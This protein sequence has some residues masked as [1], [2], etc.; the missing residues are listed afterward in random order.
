MSARKQ[1]PLAEAALA[2]L[3]SDI[4]ERFGLSFPKERW[5]DLERGLRAAAGDLRCDPM[6]L[7]ARLHSSKAR[8]EEVR[9]LA[10]RLT[11]G[12]TYFLRESRGLQFLSQHVVPSAS[13]R[14]LRIWSAGCATGEEPYSIAITLRRSIA[15]LENWGLSILA[16]D[17]NVRS[18]ETARR[19]VYGKWSFRGVPELAHGPFFTPAGEGQ[20]EIA[21]SI[22]RMVRFEE[23]NLVAPTQAP[24]SMDI[25]FCC[26]VLMYFGSKA[27]SEALDCFHRTL[28][29]GG[30]LIVGPVEQAPSLFRDFTTVAVPGGAVYRKEAGG[31]W[32]SP[33]PLLAPGPAAA[34]GLSDPPEPL[35]RPF[36]AIPVAAPAD[37]PPPPAEEPASESD[38]ALA[39]M[40][41]ARACADQ[42]QLEQAFR[43]CEMAIATGE[44]D[45]RAHYLRAAILQERGDLD[46]AARSLRRTIYLDPQFA[47]GH[48]ALGNLAALR[49]RADESSR[50]FANSLA[51]LAAHESDS[52]LPEAGGLTVARLREIIKRRTNG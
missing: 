10:N 34:F 23:A 36:A 35:D 8:P 49:G 51:A 21:P 3:E 41:L 46:E 37:E 43:W 12:E 15:D 19:G 20:W 48:F 14:R 32:P 26:N 28:A 25:I 1:E 47:L 24:E 13:R 2:A 6:E 38:R 7:A 4:G 16:T 27:L 39:L 40:R 42:G 31:V 50:H 9:G 11:V 17:L 45:A 44:A 22:R 33:Q 30:W 18:L 29:P 5:R 52:V